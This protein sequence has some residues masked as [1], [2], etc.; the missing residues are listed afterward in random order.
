MLNAIKRK[1]TQRRSCLGVHEWEVNPHWINGMRWRFCK[2]CGG[3]Q[4]L[5]TNGQAS[6]PAWRW[7]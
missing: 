3:R 5:I 1:W 2:R 4:G 6:Q 7:L